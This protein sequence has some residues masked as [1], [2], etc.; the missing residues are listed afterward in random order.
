MSALVAMILALGILAVSG[1]GGEESKVQQPQESS[2]TKAEGQPETT[3][4]TGPTQEEMESYREQLEA[5]LEAL[6]EKIDV[7]ED[8]AK[9]AKKEATREVEAMIVEA[10]AKKDEAEQ[11]LY[12]LKSA[13]QRNW[14]DLKQRADNAMGDVK[15]A[16]E[17]ATGELQQAAEKMKAPE[18]AQ[19]NAGT[20]SGQK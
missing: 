17:K 7:L 12:R 4:A 6:D 9:Q 19:E 11:A 8:E 15:Q 3:A 16:Y 1:C 5:K 13:T 10:E 20:S 18:E 2:Q 14:D